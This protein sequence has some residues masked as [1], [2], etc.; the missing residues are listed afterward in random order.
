MLESQHIQLQHLLE[1]Q[2]LAAIPSTPIQ[3][4]ET[5]PDLARLSP[6]LR[7][8]G[9]LKEQSRAFDNAPNTD[10]V[11][12][13]AHCRQ[14]SLET[15]RLWQHHQTFT[16]VIERFPDLAREPITSNRSIRALQRR[17]HTNG[18]HPTLSF[19]LHITRHQ[20]RSASAA[21]QAH[22]QQLAS[23]CSR[24][25]SIAQP[26]WPEPQCAASRIFRPRSQSPSCQ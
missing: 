2:G 19:R 13:P 25:T 3:P 8:T 7:R 10:S 20:A 12:P 18:Q 23:R 26:N 9:S 17:F 24:L 4:A 22:V 21:R 14:R 16:S 6:A 11:R 15:G 1:D 5:P